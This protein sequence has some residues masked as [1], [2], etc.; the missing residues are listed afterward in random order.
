[1]QQL[2][3]FTLVIG[4]GESGLAM[5]RWLTR[6][7]VAVR[8]AD[9]RAEPPQLAILR[10]E[11]PSV[12]FVSGQPQASWLDGVQTIALSP[13]VSPHVA[14]WAA[15]LAEAREIAVMGEI[16]LFAQALA[17]LKQSHGYAPQVVAVTG[18]NGKTTTTSLTAHLLSYA[19]K[20]VAKAGNISP[21]ALDALL[22]A[23]DNNQLP[24]IWVLELSSFQL[25]TTTHL[26]ALAATVLNISQDHLD[27]HRDM[28][29]YAAAKA[30]IFGDEQSQT[31]RI[32]NRDDPVVAAMQGSDDTPVVTFGLN[33]PTQAGDL[34]VIQENGMLW[35][36][37]AV[38][39]EG[40][41]PKGRRRKKDLA[42]V[43]I[44]LKR[45][46]PAEALRIR[47]L[48]NVA[49]ALAAL[50]LCRALGL[51][52]APILHGLRDYRGEPHRVEWIGTVKDVEFIDDSKGTN[53]GA[54]VAALKG[55]QKRVHLIAGG[56]GKG[57]DFTPLIE[58][59]VEYA[60]A[61][62]LIGKDAE[63]LQ[64]TLSPYG[65]HT[66][67]CD[68]LEAATEQ[69]FIDACAKNSAGQAVLLSPACAS[70]DMFRN[71]AHRAAV[72]A[73]TAQAIAAEHGLSWEVAC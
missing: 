4:L 31:L 35:M 41:P 27:W 73:A 7:G 52:F 5:A 66:V 70:L 15:W 9:T 18:T 20:R 21:A 56:D 46:M 61:V 50:Q 64:Q 47:G 42:P 16:E 54:T 1:M 11:L 14:P 12:E 22:T 36:V 32:L 25:E 49:N 23:L 48:H 51:S 39:L 28:A 43:E 69:A 13:G 26:N 10:S 63:A 33:A 55:L 34:G 37:E 45:L 67:R 29:D 71:Y 59:I 58:P 44:M 30:K 57:Q 65:V 24:D 17:Q 2:G 40:E 8:V 6:Q 68:T 62:Y 19:G 60:A 38:A 72:F 3:Q 53:V